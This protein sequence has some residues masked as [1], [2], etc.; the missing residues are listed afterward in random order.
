MAMPFSAPPSGSEIPP[1]SEETSVPT[2]PLGAPASV[3]FRTGPA[4]APAVAARISILIGPSLPLGVPHH[5]AGIVQDAAGAVIA[6]VP[7]TWSTDDASIVS[8]DAVA[9]VITG[10]SLGTTIVRASAAGL[11]GEVPVTVLGFRS[12][13]TPGLLS[14]SQIGTVGN[15]SCGI[16]AVT[17]LAYCWGDNHQG[18]L[19]AGEGDGTDGPL[20]VAGPLRLRS[21]SVG[22]YTTCGIES[23]TGL[24]YCWGGSWESGTTTR[25]W[26]PALVADGGMRFSAI[27]T[28][29]GATCGVEAVTSRGFCWKGRTV[30]LPVDGGEIRFASIST[31]DSHGCGI[32]AG[33]GR[34]YCWGLNRSGQLGDGTAETR[35]APTLV[36]DGRIRFGSI[37]ASE[38]VTC[39]VEAE[40]GRGYCWGSNLRGQLGDGTTTERLLPALVGGGTPRFASIDAGTTMSCGVEAG[41]GVGYCWGLNDVG[42]LGVGS[43]ADRLLPAMVASGQLRF[44]GISVD[45][46]RPCGVEVRTGIAYCWGPWTFVPE[47]IAPPAPTASM[48]RS[49]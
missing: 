11:S 12:P 24:A 23:G 7:I 27:S 2:A 20:L 13:Q 19:G 47:P 3:P 29:G 22:Y 37:S 46:G 42:S 21:I 28:S 43:P 30:P 40:T 34:A 32:E 6:D 45:G 35:P 48:N 1:V 18:A 9:G 4:P 10:R 5:L 41:S 15:F 17:D 44:S 31:S 14:F 33:T 25:R 16:E 8:V 26:V 36:A 38:R 49:Q 39:G